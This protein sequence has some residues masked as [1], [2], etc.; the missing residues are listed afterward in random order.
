VGG[1]DI[2]Y[3]KG[4]P[5]LMKRFLVEHGVP[6][7]R[8]LHDSLSFNTI[9]NWQQ[10]LLIMEKQKCDTVIAISAPLHIFRISRIIDAPSV[11]YCAYEYKPSGLTDYWQIFKDVHH[12]FLSHFLSFALKDSIRNQVIKIYRTIRFEVARFF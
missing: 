7:D 10:A 3:W 12:E 9:T 6:A 2:S 5:H 4:R 11:Y 8:I 1:Y